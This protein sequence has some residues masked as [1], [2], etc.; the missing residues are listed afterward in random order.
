MYISKQAR[1]RKEHI[2]TDGS[3]SAHSPV[4][5]SVI[6]SARYAVRYEDR[7]QVVDGV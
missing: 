7:S 6:H 1:A 5:T 3:A 4:H 2:S